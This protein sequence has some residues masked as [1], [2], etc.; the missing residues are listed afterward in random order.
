[1]CNILFYNGTILG[2]DGPIEN[3]YVLIKGGIIA[4]VGKGKPICSD[5][6][7]PVDLCGNILSPGFIDM[8]THGAGGC[9]FM[10]GTVDAIVT[11]SR[12]H[13]KHG[14]TTI[15]P[16]SVA[17]ED[18][19][20]FEFMDCY[21]KAKSIKENMPHLA[22]I[23]L[24]GPYFSPSQAGA[25]QPERMKQPLPDHYLRV[26]ERSNGNIV[27][28]SSAPEV[29]GVIEIGDELVRNGIIPSIAHTDA[30]CF[31]VKKAM[32][33]GYNLLTHFYS[34]MSILKR[35]N[36]HRVLGVVEAGYLYDDL[37]IELIADGIH[38]PKELLQLILKC[39]PHDHIILVTDSMRAAGMPDGPSILGSLKNNFQVIVEDGVAKMPDRQSF[40]G[41]VATADRL[42]RV[43]VHE[44][45]LPLHEAVDMITKNPAK[46]LRI[47]HKTGS[48][49]EGKSADLVVFDK[50]IQIQQVYVEGVR[51]SF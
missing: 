9:D 3:G 46:L 27:R 38:L 14:T 11:A 47:D 44:A 20:L 41:S 49:A 29:P 34:G 19:E 7:E 26:L 40:A 22:G 10:D 6:V 50:D 4:E 39:K 18:D 30:D 37:Y 28:W 12:M 33:H 2:A 15:C 1:M 48:I 16:T 24:E 35:V 13:L 25:Q 5:A 51:V 23:H 8:H 17:S 36:G 21:E 43:M 32:E 31:T 45:G 42:V